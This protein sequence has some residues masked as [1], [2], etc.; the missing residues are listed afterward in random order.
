[1]ESW[2]REKYALP[3]E[4]DAIYHFLFEGAP[5]LYNPSD[6]FS[7]IDYLMDNMWLMGNTQN[8][9]VHYET[10][11][12]NPKI[13]VKKVNLTPVKYDF[14]NCP[15]INT[16]AKGNIPSQ[17]N[18]T[19]DSHK[20]SVD[21]IIC[22]YNAFEDVR[23][24]INSVLQY[25]NHPYHIIIVDDNSAELTASYLR[26]LASDNKDITLIVNTSDMHGYTYAANIGL[27]N[28]HADYCIMLNSDTIVS[29]HWVDNMIACAKSNDKIG[30]VGPLS[31]TASW[32]SVPKLVD[33]DGD[34]C[35][36]DL[37]LDY[38]IEQTAKIIEENSGKIFPKVPL[39][40]GFCLMICRKVIDT[41]GF[42]DEENFGR[43]FAEEDD[44]N[45]RA[46]KAGFKLA[47]ADNTYVYHSQS[48]SYTDEKRLQ[49]CKLSGEAL[50]KKHGQEYIDNCSKYMATNDVLDAIRKKG[51]V[52]FEKENLIKECK[53]KY[54]GKKILILLPS[55]N[56]SGGANVIIQEGLALIKMG[57]DITFLNL[58][59]NQNNYNETYGNLSVPVIWKESY[60][61]FDMQLASKYDAVICTLFR[62]V[63]Y[64]RFLAKIDSPKL[65]YYIQDYEPY[66]IQEELLGDDY[67]QDEYKK[68][69]CSYTLIPRCINVTKTEW[70]RNEVYKNTGADCKV[71]GPSVNTSLFMPRFDKPIAPLVISAM[72]RPSTKRRG[73][74]MTYDILRALKL[75]FG[76]S[77]SIRIFG[78]DPDTD[79]NSKLFFAKQKQDFEY[80]NY[81]L[82]S[83][84][85]TSMILAE[86][87]IF[88]DLSEFQ[89]MGLTAME[90]MACG[91][92]TVVPVHGGT[93]SFAKDRKNCLVIDTLDYKEC[94]QAGRNLIIDKQLRESLR[95]Q[96]YLD[97]I[98]FYPEKSAEKLLNSIF[99][100]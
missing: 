36:N 45:T 70:N 98:E 63:E 75:E 100:S 71:I 86:S 29:A 87:N 43:G 26:E 47:I 7:T 94:L 93:S 44:Y 37:P 52:L 32:Q 17:N 38:T 49:L 3:D 5:Q 50:R 79:L 46:I 51:S 19:I 21:I 16:K 90:A 14:A 27:K 8:P 6:N 41:I 1:M 59:S 34:W 24:C 96:A 64:C 73:P 9:L 80:I 67:D 89:A 22:V 55:G 81:G 61:Q 74:Q 12:N 92:A 95:K 97:M 18:N 54:A 10:N 78:A 77:I 30:V 56:A 13:K 58:L 25:T 83:P 84:W 99:N 28:S 48:K 85:E 69:V 31:N 65:A 88:L 60:S 72:I 82:T 35:H 66:F 23:K 53:S 40:N 4:M 57:V 91:C 2:Y 76:E 62:T 39:L 20:E 68:A 42:F 15:I 33:E 11:K